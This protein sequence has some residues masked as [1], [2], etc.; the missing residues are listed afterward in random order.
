MIFAVFLLPAQAASAHTALVSSSPEAGTTLTAT[1]SEVSI[2][3]SESLMLI[4]QENPN[5]LEVRDESG[6]LVSTDAIVEGPRISVQL[7]PATGVLE[8][9]YHVVASDGH[10]VE[11]NYQFSVESPLVI[12]APTSP[13]TSAEDGPNL[14][15]RAIW[16]LLIISAIGTLTLL[17]RRK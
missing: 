16:A 10:V 13:D 7:T 17:R 2:E 9:S 6:Q 1:P 4:G 12:S 14:L 8:V 3:F 11:G 15:I 5:R